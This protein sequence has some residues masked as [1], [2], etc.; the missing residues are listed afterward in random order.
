MDAE[1]LLKEN[2]SFGSDHFSMFA[3]KTKTSYQQFPLSETRAKSSSRRGAM[4]NNVNCRFRRRLN[5]RTCEKEWRG[6]GWNREKER[7]PAGAEF[8]F[9]EL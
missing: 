5:S 3:P 4:V 7:V 1:L 9:G 2:G 6:V 8:F